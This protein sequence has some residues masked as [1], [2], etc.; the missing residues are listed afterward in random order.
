[1]GLIFWLGERGTIPSTLWVL[2]TLL[3]SQL[4]LLLDLGSF[5]TSMCWS[6]LLHML[7]HSVLYI[8]GV[9]SLSWACC[10]L[11]LHRHSDPCAQLQN[12]KDFPPELPPIV[13]YPGNNLWSISWG[14]HSFVSHNCRGPYPVWT[15]LQSLTNHCFTH[16]LS[17]P[18]SFGGKKAGRWIQSCFYIF[19]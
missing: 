13:L 15:D 3:P 16:L 5:L 12:H 14:N 2:R 6:G 9:L 18:P 19:A 1:M 10:F 4:G 8:S 17:L 11:C 7:K